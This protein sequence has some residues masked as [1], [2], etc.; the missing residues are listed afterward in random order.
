MQQYVT[1][2]VARCPNTQYLIYPPK[3][4]ELKN[5]YGKEHGVQFSFEINGVDNLQKRN[6]NLGILDKGKQIQFVDHTY[7]GEEGIFAKHTA[8]NE[9]GEISND[10]LTFSIE[11]NVKQLKD[12]FTIDFYFNRNIKRFC[13]TFTIPANKGPLSD[14][15]SSIQVPLNTRHCFEIAWGRHN[16]K[17]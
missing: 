1:S 7:D 5:A 15:G 2:A 17:Q 13:I 14:K 10:D 4:E 3:G 9:S 8:Y 11:K 12:G 6:K 16:T